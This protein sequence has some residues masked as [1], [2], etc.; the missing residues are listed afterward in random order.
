ML[1]DIREYVGQKEVEIEVVGLRRA[2][3]V[4]QVEPELWIVGNDHLCYGCD[5]EFTKKAAKKY[6]KLTTKNIRLQEKIQ[7]IFQ[8]VSSQERIREQRSQDVLLKERGAWLQG[9]QDK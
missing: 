7:E 4:D 2:C 6:K 8:A 5:V 9:S 3:R 1:V